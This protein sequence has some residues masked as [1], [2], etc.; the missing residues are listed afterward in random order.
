M[1]TP[2]TLYVPI[3]QDAA[4]QAAAKQVY[5]TF[6]T[7]AHTVLDQSKILHYVRLA[8]VPNAQGTEGYLALLLITTFDGAM[9]PYLNYFWGQPA[10]KAV[11][12]GITE[13][14]LYP[15]NPAVTDLTGF[16]NF[17]NAN[18]LNQPQDLYQAYPQTVIQIAGAFPPTQAAAQPA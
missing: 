6:T 12:V 2:L 7:E 13:V 14:A 18:N 4:S 1:A 10:V 11:F 8:L 17:I 5:D 3:K 16:I 9:N 15:P